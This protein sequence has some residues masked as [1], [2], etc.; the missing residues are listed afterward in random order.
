MVCYTIKKCIKFPRG[1]LFLYFY[2]FFKVG[3]LLLLVPGL[4][5][6]N[7]TVSSPNHHHK[8]FIEDENL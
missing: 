3:V 4:R 7:I 5:P 2:D 8:S 6:V 1:K